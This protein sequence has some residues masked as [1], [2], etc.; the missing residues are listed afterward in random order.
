MHPIQ[1]RRV[2]ELPD[3]QVLAAR[4]E[5]PGEWMKEESPGHVQQEVEAVSNGRISR[6]FYL[7]ESG[8]AFLS[9][10]YCSI[11]QTEPDLKIALLRCLLSPPQRAYAP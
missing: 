11:L 4:Q 5:P 7:N 9:F 3:V 1:S 8:F 10:S 6:K 2:K